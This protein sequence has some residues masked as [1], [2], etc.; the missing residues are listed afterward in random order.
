M[1]ELAAVTVVK[2]LGSSPQLE[3]QTDTEV[4]MM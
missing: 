2:A 1:P 3:F 4:K